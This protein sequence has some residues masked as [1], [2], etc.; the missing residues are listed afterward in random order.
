MSVKNL[1]IA[2]LI[3]NFLSI[4]K[5]FA[6]KGQADGD[7][8]KEVSASIAA[9]TD[10]IWRG[11]SL[12]TNKPALHGEFTLM[13]PKSPIKGLY[14]DLWFSNVRFFAD[15]PLS[16][17]S[18]EIEE[19]GNSEETSENEA[20]KPKR[21][22][23]FMQED[24]SHRAFMEF[25]TSI[26]I[27]NEINKNASYDIWFVRYLYPGATNLDYNELSGEF[28]FFFLT[29]DIGLTN[30]VYNTGG[31]ALYCNFGYDFA[32]PESLL[33]FKQVRLRGGIGHYFLPEISGSNSYTDY[34]LQI[35]KTY[36]KFAFNLLWT[37]TNDKISPF[38]GSK[39]SFEVTAYL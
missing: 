13:I 3:I 23:I 27:S 17:N 19:S 39:V 21:E 26:G 30:N 32:V 35:Q 1:I 34:N 8:N 5:G 14:F 4:N 36:K 29:S 16:D 6:G 18:P 38:G 28:K 10:Y 7:N 33:K 37:K 9:T 31:K 11:F 15:E 25:D 20:P 2:V 12:T 22:P 24:G